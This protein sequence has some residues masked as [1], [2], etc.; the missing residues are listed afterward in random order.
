VTTFTPLPSVGLGQS[1]ISTTSGGLPVGYPTRATNLLDNIPVYTAGGYTFETWFKFTG[2]NT[3][4]ILTLIIC[5]SIDSHRVDVV[6]VLYSCQSK[7]LRL[8]WTNVPP[9]G[10]HNSFNHNASQ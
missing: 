1:G 6:F 4:S 8:W 2:P 3:T 7:D 5:R 10:S 9:F